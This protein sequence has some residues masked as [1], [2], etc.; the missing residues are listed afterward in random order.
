MKN[1]P[2]NKV[3]ADVKLEIEKKREVYICSAAK[4]EFKSAFEF[5]IA[6]ISELVRRGESGN[7][8]LCD[9]RYLPISKENLEYELK[10][11]SSNLDILLKEKTF[12]SA[13]KMRYD[14]IFSGWYFVETKN[15]YHIIDLTR[16]N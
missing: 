10:T 2:K 7:S 14:K 8:D 4:K 9:G 15:Q 13:M 3:S 12:Q 11:L 16:P 1:Y 6:G 5:W